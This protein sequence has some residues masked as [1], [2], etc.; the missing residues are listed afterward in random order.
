MLTRNYDSLTVGYLTVF[1]SGT[2]TEA[3][4]LGGM[5]GVIK[6]HD[7]EIKSINEM[8]RASCSIFG[9]LNNADYFSQLTSSNNTPFLLVGSNNAAETY[10]DYKLQ[11]VGDL[12][13]V[14]YRS[15]SITYSVDGCKYTTVKSF[16]NNTGNDITVNEL[17]L[18]QFNNSASH[19]LL[20]RKKLANPVTLKAKGGTA[21]FSLV[22]DIPY[23][24]K[25]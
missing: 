1:P 16:I 19:I 25:P 21:T 11:I 6:N 9:N 3:D 23:A 5:P 10:E 24:N 4:W 20:Y 14:G 22:I 13:A 12:T 18:Y 2:L 7:G 8:Q 15:A 17:G